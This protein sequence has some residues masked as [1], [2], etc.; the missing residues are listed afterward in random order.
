MK[1]I[2]T[3]LCSFILFNCTTKSKLDNFDKPP[4]SYVETHY[5]N[6]KQDKTILLDTVTTPYK[7]NMFLYKEKGIKNILYLSS[8][9]DNSL[10]RYDWES[11]TIIDK[12]KLP[13]EGPDGVAIINSFFVNSNDSI[14]LL[15]SFGFKLT[16]VNRDYK[17]LRNYS[18]LPP[19]LN[20]VQLGQGVL[21]IGKQACA[22]GSFQNKII[23][24]GRSFMSTDDEKFYTEGKT[25]IQLDKITGSIEDFTFTPKNYIEKFREGFKLVEQNSSHSQTFN[26]EKNLMIISNRTDSFLEVIDINTKSYNRVYAGSN[27]T[28]NIPWLKGKLSDDEE[29]KFFN[30]NPYYSSIY[31]DKF[32]KVY[33]R[34]FEFPNPKKIDDYDEQSWTIPSVIILNDNFEK[35]GETILSPE[36][37]MATSIITEK[38]LYLQKYN[39]SEDKIVFTLFNLEKK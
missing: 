31:Y 28:G 19:G 26:Y 4:Y 36:F 21:A 5:L 38:G 12:K 7:N 30:K 24:G 33:Y 27:R 32:R 14:F 17:V 1:K 9:L 10:Q 35:I 39:K 25:S 11:G 2:L 16:L 37:S 15:N 13:K 20:K 6:S 18:L 34:L 29:F 23:I 8:D 22:F 3:I